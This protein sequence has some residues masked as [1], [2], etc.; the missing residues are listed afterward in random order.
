MMAVGSGRLA[1]I[2]AALVLVGGAAHAVT[3]IGPADSFGFELGN[4]KRIFTNKEGNYR[5]VV[6]SG[7]DVSEKGQFTEILAPFIDSSWVRTRLLITVAEASD[8]LNFTDFARRYSN[9]VGW[10]FG[11][12]G[13]YISIQREAKLKEDR[14]LFVAR[15]LKSPGEV[16][17]ISVDGGPDC[18]EGSDFDRVKSS[19][20]TFTLLE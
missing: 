6:N 15:I 5:M 7:S 9:R 12:I 16:T 14:C 13:N 8:V 11:K 17:T 20:S 4:G 3:P 18:Q 2:L 10:S 19:L 1:L